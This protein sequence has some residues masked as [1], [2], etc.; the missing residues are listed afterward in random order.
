MVPFAGPVAPSGYLMCFGQA[1]SR[2]TYAPLFEALTI[3]QTVGDQRQCQRD[4]A[5][6][7][8]EHAGSGCR[9]RGTAFKLGR[10]SLRLFREPRSRSPLN[11]NATNVASEIVVAPSGWATGRRPST[12][13]TFGEGRSLGS[14]TWGTAASRPRPPLQ[15]SPRLGSGALGVPRPHVLTTAQMPSHGHTTNTVGDHNHT[16]YG[17]VNTAGGSVEPRGLRPMRMLQRVRGRKSLSPRTAA[18]W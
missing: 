2:A 13:P 7:H 16:M 10:R 6:R 12:S 8:V 5:C 17:Q 18:R 3:R 14:I 15:V 11:A 9:S 1:V 4:G